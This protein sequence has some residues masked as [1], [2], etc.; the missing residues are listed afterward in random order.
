MEHEHLSWEARVQAVKLAPM[1]TVDWGEAQEAD[2][3][4]ATCHKSLHLRRDM[5]LPKQD[6]LLKECLGAEA[7]TEQGKTLFYICNSFILNKGLM[8]V[9]TTPKG[10]TEEVLAFVVP[11]GQCH[12]ALNGVHHDA[13]HQGQERTLALLRKDFGGP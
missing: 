5:P 3:A 7:E 2:T 9:S 12:M 4:L 10:E 6:A 11:M 13:G 8:Y 1:H